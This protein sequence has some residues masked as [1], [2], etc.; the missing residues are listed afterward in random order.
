VNAGGQGT[1]GSAS[2]IGNGEYEATFTATS[3]GGNT[4]LAFI[5]N[6]NVTSK[7]EPIKVISAA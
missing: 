7:A 6:S 1:I 5:G 4:V 3:V 2:Y